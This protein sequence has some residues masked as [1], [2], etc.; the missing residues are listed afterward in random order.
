MKNTLAIFIKE[1]KS[2]F[3]SPMGYFVIASDY[4]EVIY[5]RETAGDVSIDGIFKL[6]IMRKVVIDP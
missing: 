6:D 5:F 1:L 3:V 2:Y 4:D